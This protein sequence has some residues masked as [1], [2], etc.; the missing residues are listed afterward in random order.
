MCLNDSCQAQ[1]LLL[2]AE[3]EFVTAQNKA[4]DGQRLG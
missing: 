3:L 1:H 4:V 2:I